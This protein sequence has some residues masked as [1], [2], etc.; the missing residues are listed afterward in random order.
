MLE[1]DQSFIYHALNI[2]NPSIIYEKSL[3]W[4]TLNFTAVQLKVNYY[5]KNKTMGNALALIIHT[6]INITYMFL[7]EVRAEE[8]ESYTQQLH[9]KTTKLLQLWWWA[10]KEQHTAARLKVGITDCWLSQFLRIH[11]FL[12]FFKV[13]IF[14]L[15][16]KSISH[17]HKIS[18][19]SFRKMTTDNSLWSIQTHY[20]LL[21]FF[22]SYWQFTRASSY[23]CDC[24]L[25]PTFILMSKYTTHERQYHSH[26][27]W[28]IAP[29]KHAAWANMW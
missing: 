16:L 8:S 25:D 14:H 27:P 22:W 5:Y 2:E 20:S 4:T 24:S 6:S 29:F 17:S 23:L 3:W 9:W 12:F 18:F 26:S 15:F 7:M 28:W 13:I 19:T 10:E 21:P 11:I 1:K